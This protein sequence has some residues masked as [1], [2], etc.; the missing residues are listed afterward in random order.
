MAGVSKKME[1]HLKGGREL[2]WKEKQNV[3]S[4]TRAEKAGRAEELLRRVGEGAFGVTWSS[5]ENPESWKLQRAKN[6][7]PKSQSQNQ[8]WRARAK[9][10]AEEPE[11]EPKS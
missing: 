4:S 7:K 10:R 1:A 3:E 6:P 2:N 9:T 5:S 8:S 11:P